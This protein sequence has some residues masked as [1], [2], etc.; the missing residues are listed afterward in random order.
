MNTYFTGKVHI[1]LAYSKPPKVQI[2]E[3]DE[4]VQRALLARGVRR[5][6]WEF[7]TPYICGGVFVLVL[8]MQAAGVFD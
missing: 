7:L 2:D 8:L 1:G 6:N 4:R 5:V 3:H